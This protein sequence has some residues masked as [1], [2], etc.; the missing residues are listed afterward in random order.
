M[1]YYII[2]PAGKVPRIAPSLKN[3]ETQASGAKTSVSSQTGMGISGAI[4]SYIRALV[5][6]V[7]DVQPTNGKNVQNPT[8]LPT[9]LL[10]QFQFTFLIRHP[11]RAI[12][13]YYRCTVPPL[14]EVTG[15]RYFDPAEAG[16]RE[17]RLLIEYLMKAQLLRKD[18][19]ILIDAD[20][21]LNNPEGIIRKYCERVGVDF[22]LDM[23]KW[24]ED[25]CE[26]FEKWKGFHAD[27]I[28]SKGLIARRTV[29]DFISSP[30]FLRPVLMISAAGP[31]KVRR[32]MLPG[33][34]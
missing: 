14:A 18:D 32:R 22:S 9:K 17:T 1:A 8:V 4:F 12:P 16:F 25:E 34:G 3:S 30:D 19:V 28:K 13:S 29:S 23:L 26:D 33:M 27:A 7:F 21:L 2:P 6:W 24:E 15:F 5:H 11:S 20:D 31:A 10:Q